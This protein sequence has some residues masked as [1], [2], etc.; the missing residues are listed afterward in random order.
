MADNASVIGLAV[1]PFPSFSG[2]VDRLRRTHRS[3]A[4]TRNIILEDVLPS[5]D[6]TEVRQR[7]YG[8]GYLIPGDAAHVLGLVEPFHLNGASSLLDLSSGLGGPARAIA[9]AFHARV[10]GLERDPDLVR[11]H[12][13]MSSALGVSSLVRVK[14][15]DPEAVELD[16]GRYDCALG[17]EATYMVA[18]KERLLRVVVQAL[19]SRGQ[20]ILT[21]FVLD[22]AAG[23]RDE[24][25]RWSD[26]RTRRPSLWTV[27]QYADCFRSL[28][29]NLRAI[30]DSTALHRRQIVAAWIT[31]L[32]S[33][34]IR[35]LSPSQVET[36]LSEAES[37]L[38]TA[39]ALESG[40]LKYYRFE[41]IAHHSFW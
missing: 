16:A 10:L 3:R 15:C 37:C 11:R 39:A 22:R 29:F 4:H 40:A 24:L 27:G 26:S 34:D 18:E 30:D 38:R 1:R 13:A 20:I 9:Q 12:A 14:G 2:M 32:R 21:D 35:R 17:R 6:T 8:R 36:V 33:R 19:K 5:L 7:L 28:G 23:E 31:L 41:A 25:A